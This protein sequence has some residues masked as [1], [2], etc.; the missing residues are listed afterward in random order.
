MYL[1]KVYRW[2]ALILPCSASMPKPT[3]PQKRQRRPAE[4]PEE[5]ATAALRLFCEN[6]YHA[7]SIDEVAQAAGVTKGAVYHHF[8]SK[9]DLLETAMITF[10]DEAFQQATSSE[11]GEFKRD[12]VVQVRA[13]LRAATELWTKPE[14]LAAFCLV[15]G[16][17]GKTVP[18]LRT[19]F[20]E[21]GPSRAWRALAEIIGEGQKRGAFRADVD[22]FVTAR[23]MACSLVLQGVLLPLAGRS[24]IQVRRA[25]QESVE[26]QLKLLS[27]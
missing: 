1:R 6:G 9:E 13:L 14:A 18:N 11:T 26:T 2:R 27:V 7:T 21:R 16:E 8:G 19:C 4:R 20:L 15:F 17:V 24:R 3:P 23:S 10:F 22:S 5:I 25:L 12:P